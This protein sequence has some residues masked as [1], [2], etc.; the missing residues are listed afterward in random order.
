MVQ[1]GGEVYST[2]VGTTPHTA[3]GM[4]SGRFPDYI[5]G[6]SGWVKGIRVEQNSHELIFPEWV[7]AYAD[8]YTCYDVFYLSDYVYDPEFYYGGPGRSYRCP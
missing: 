4:G 5:F 2:R 6:T 3:T 1:W 7:N 8:E